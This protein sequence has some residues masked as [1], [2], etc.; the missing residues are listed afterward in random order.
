[1]YCGK[2]GAKVPEG[3]RFCNACGTPVFGERSKD[4]NAASAWVKADSV[5]AFI[6][7]G[8]ILVI[9]GIFLPWISVAVNGYGYSTGISS[10]LGINMGN[11]AVVLMGGILSLAALILAR[12]GATGRWGA[13][14]LLLSGLMLV[15]V[16][17]AMYQIRHHIGA[18]LFVT[19]VGALAIIF[20][21]FK[22][23]GARK[24]A[25]VQRNET[26]LP[27][28]ARELGAMNKAIVQGSKPLSP[29]PANV[30]D[31]LKKLKQLYDSGALTA[32]EY[33]EQKKI[34]LQKL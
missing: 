19:L 34:L 20:G 32:V 5:M 4:Q 3:N 16:F 1:M 33:E 21:S 10:T 26:T 18:G 31:E 9:I 13:V 30:E 8:A 7:L 24:N 2:C 28:P 27:N 22:E 11:G 12:S 6:I 23:F 17:Q 15:L 25:P 14:M 29:S